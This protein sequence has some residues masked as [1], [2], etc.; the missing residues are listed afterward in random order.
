MKKAISLALSALLSIAILAGCGASSRSAN[1]SGSAASTSAGAAAPASSQEASK[2]A[3]GPDGRSF[4][5]GKLNNRY[6]IKVVKPTQYNEI[7]FADKEGFLDQVGLDIEYIGSLPQ[8]VSLA[9]AVTTGLVD[10]F[11]SG[12]TTTIVNARQAGVKL[13]IVNAGTVD[14]PDFDKTHMTWFVGEDSDIKTAA[15]LK[16]KT[17]ALGSLGGCAELWN[18][19]LLQQNGLT[20]DDVTVTVISNEL[21]QEQALRQKQVDVIILHGPNN[22]VAYANGGLRILAKSYDIAQAAGDGALSAVGVRAFT[23]DFIKEH[24]AVVKA[25]VTAVNRAQVWA[26]KNYDKAL[27]DAAEFLEVDPKLITGTDYTKSLW[28]EGDKIKFWVETAEKIKLAGFETPGAVNP[29]DLYTNDYNPF[30]TGE[31]KE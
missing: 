22:K 24:P 13:K 27:A 31:L 1:G 3:A 21:A 10:V 14:S 29:E 4:E 18:D 6:T 15:E 23:E 5:N 19:V 12:H 2:A 11:G 9:Q 25:Y 8:N 30:F 26:A 17:I 28:V 20:K 16:G 7:I